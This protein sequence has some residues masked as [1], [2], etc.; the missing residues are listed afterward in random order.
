MII[1]VLGHISSG[2][3]AMRIPIIAIVGAFASGMFAVYHRAQ[4]QR[5]MLQLYHAERMAAIEKGIELPPLPPEVFQDQD[6]GHHGKR[7]LG[8]SRYRGVITLLVGVAVTLALRQS[9][10]VSTPWWWGLVIVAVGLGQLL[11]GYL[12]RDNASAASA[13]PSAQPGSNMD[14]PRS[15]RSWPGFGVPQSESWRGRGFP[16][17]NHAPPGR[18]GAGFEVRHG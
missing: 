1:P 12:E 18:S 16:R 8:R 15:G 2:V 17:G 13:G 14:P 5:E 6:G 9:P 4:R 10:G 11:T 7:Y 3:L